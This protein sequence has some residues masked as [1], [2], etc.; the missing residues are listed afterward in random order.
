MEDKSCSVL[1]SF[2]KKFI[3][4][5][6]KTVYLSFNFQTLTHL[7]TFEF[8]ASSP[9]IYIYISFFRINSRK[10]GGEEKQIL[11]FKYM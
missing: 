6:I 4:Q 5:E 8:F 9:F 2:V 10:T 11:I 7:S 1:L 3:N